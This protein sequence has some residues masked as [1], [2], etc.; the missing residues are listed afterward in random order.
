MIK[1]LTFTAAVLVLCVLTEA[2]FAVLLAS[3]ATCFTAGIP[4]ALSKACSPASIWNRNPARKH[5]LPHIYISSSP[6]CSPFLS[7]RFKALALLPVEHFMTVKK[8]SN[9]SYNYRTSLL[10]CFQSTCKRHLRAKQGNKQC[11]NQSDK[12]IWLQTNMQ[13]QPELRMIAE[14][15]KRPPLPL[16]QDIA[17]QTQK[18]MQTR[19]KIKRLFL[20]HC[21]ITEAVWSSFASALHEASPRVWSRGPTGADMTWHFHCYH[22]R[23]ISRSVTGGCSSFANRTSSGKLSSPQRKSSEEMRG[24]LF[25]FSYWIYRCSSGAF[26]LTS[27]LL[28]YLRTWLHFVSLEVVATNKQTDRHLGLK[29]IYL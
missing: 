26:K 9:Q 19:N 24:K 14:Q 3:T 10:R 23:S 1:V 21:S 28:L 18:G 11:P 15:S 25:G 29:N 22:G 27:L 12:R 13:I 7:V 4:A 20:D 8:S 6:W 16:T 2:W 17:V 5:I